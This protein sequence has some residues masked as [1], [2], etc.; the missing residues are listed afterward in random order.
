MPDSSD[1]FV[2]G[3][4]SDSHGR[5]DPRALDV[6]RDAGVG[7]IIHAGDIGSHE[8]LLELEAIAPVTA[9]RGNTDPAW[10]G[11]RLEERETVV[12]CG[13]RFAVTHEPATMRAWA[14]PSDTRVAVTGHT[15]RPLVTRLGR[16]LDVNPGSVFRPR[17]PEGRSIAL[18]TVNPGN[19]EV[20]AR[21]VP[22]ESI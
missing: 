22:L 20:E 2:V 17:G 15:H 13:A 14:V 3:V 10:L 7:H 6:M 16:R 4:L 5:L 19:G 9:V 11:I 18:V 1:T 8:V 21:I 12:L